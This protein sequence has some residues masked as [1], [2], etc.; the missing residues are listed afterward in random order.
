[1]TP[2][3]AIFALTTPSYLKTRSEPDCSTVQ[4]DED[5]LVAVAALPVHVPATVAD[6]ALPEQLEEVAAL[7]LMLIA[8]VPDAPVPSVLGAPTV[9]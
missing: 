5:I 3:E 6:A 1:M 4:F 8:Q 9:L 2:S 7:P